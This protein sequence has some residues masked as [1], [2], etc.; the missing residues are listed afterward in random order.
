MLEYPRIQRYSPQ[1]SENPFGA[2]NQQGRFARFIEERS[3]LC[4]V[5]GEATMMPSPLSL[6]ILFGT[7]DKKKL[8]QRRRIVGAAL[9]LI[10]VIGIALSL[11]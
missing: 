11:M 4:H 1:G 5:K 2:D 9:V 7:S 10:V 3:L 8:K 6:E